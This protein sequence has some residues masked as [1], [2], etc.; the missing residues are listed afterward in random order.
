MKRKYE[1]RVIEIEHAS[2]IPLIFSLTGG[3]PNITSHFYRHLAEKIV[4]KKHSSCSE[5]I[6]LI[7][8]KHQ[9]N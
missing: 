5:T 8:P 2:F 1:Q 7:K 6:A 3:K 9:Q 4:E